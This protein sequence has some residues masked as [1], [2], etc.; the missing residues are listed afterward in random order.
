MG[1]AF[2]IPKV[3]RILKNGIDPDS[4]VP[5]EGNDNDLEFL[6]GDVNTTTIDG[7]PAITFSDCL[8]NL[9][10]R[11]MEFTVIVKLLGLNNGYNALHNH[12]LSLWKPINSFRI[13]DTTNGYFLLNFRLLRITTEFCRMVLVDRAIQ[14]VEYE[15]LPT[16]C[17]NCG[18]YG[19]VKD[20]CPMV[21]TDPNPT[22]ASGKQSTV[23]DVSNESKSN[24]DSIN[25]RSKEKEP[26][27]GPW[28]LVKNRHSKRGR[29][30]FS[31]K[32]KDNQRRASTR[33]FSR[34]NGNKKE[35]ARLNSLKARVKLDSRSIEPTDLASGTILN[36]SKDRKSGGSRSNRKPSFALRGRESRFKTSGNT[37]IP[38]VESMEAMAELISLQILSQNLRV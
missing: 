17:F 12:I 33:G 21:E 2:P 30:D 27:F 25:S 11:E 14:H 28:M 23:V 13:M 36:S 18:K 5:T 19:H 15:A 22:M 24:G 16:I 8:K 6:E 32:I 29:R 31:A 7:V 1:M 37:R 35:A 10:L 3:I 26:E 9:L 4:T 34:E 20:M 38:L